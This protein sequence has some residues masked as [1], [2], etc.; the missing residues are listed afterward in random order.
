MF[1]TN[2]IIESIII[3]CL[4]SILINYKPYEVITITFVAI[5]ALIVILLLRKIS[6]SLGKDRQKFDLRNVNNIMQSLRYKRNYF[7]L[8]TA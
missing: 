2:I 6:R 5:I 7:K 4:I 1:I 3:I 8:K